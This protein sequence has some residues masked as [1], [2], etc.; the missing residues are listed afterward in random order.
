MTKDA[1]IHARIEPFL[2]REAEKILT[3][4][5]LSSA[6]AVRLF[7][8]QICLRNGLPFDLTLP[9][10]NH[11]NIRL[12]D[13]VIKIIIKC[14]NQ[15]FLPEDELI[16]FGSRVNL[17]KKG[18]DIDLCIKTALSDYSEAEER[19]LLFLINLKKL[20]GEQKIDVVLRLKNKL[21]NEYI[22]TIILKEGIK[23]I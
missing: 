2:K 10:K 22:D 7:Y 1:L 18:G 6:E 20:I 21:L 14:F 13:D 9:K 15:C 12:P 5:G 8:K 17:D 3:A 19:K 11:A 23:L 16:L 4:I